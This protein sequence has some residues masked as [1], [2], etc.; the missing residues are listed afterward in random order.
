M[1]ASI[2]GRSIQENEKILILSD[3]ATTGQTILKAANRIRNRGGSIVGSLVFL[4]NEYS[5]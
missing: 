3:V 2:R 1:R 4:D 5:F